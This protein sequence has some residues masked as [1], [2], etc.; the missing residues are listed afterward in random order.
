MNG[1]FSVLCFSCSMFS[2]PSGVSVELICFI[3]YKTTT[4]TTHFVQHNDGLILM[5]IW[6]NCK[7]SKYMYTESCCLYH[8]STFTIWGGWVDWTHYSS[9]FITDCKVSLNTDH[10]VDNAHWE[11]YSVNSL[12]HYSNYRTCNYDIL[13]V[14]IQSCTCIYGKPRESLWKHCLLKKSETWLDYTKVHYSWPHSDLVTSLCVYFMRGLY[15]NQNGFFLLQRLTKILVTCSSCCFLLRFSVFFLPEPFPWNRWDSCLKASFWFSM[16]PLSSTYSSLTSGLYPSFSLKSWI[17][18]PPPLYLSLF[19]LY[20]SSRSLSNR[21]CTVQPMSLQTCYKEINCHTCVL[22]Q[23]NYQQSHVLMNQYN[24]GF[25]WTLAM[26]DM[27]L[28]F[29][30]FKKVNCSHSNS[31]SF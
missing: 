6:I 28:L 3:S 10:K 29:S 2:V 27:K 4:A 8:T 16:R 22:K 12:Y 7:C 14:I 23:T 31:I 1:D 19:L 9:C 25:Q 18:P 15:I 5:P 13:L 21:I 11:S 20:F 17:I 24:S 30:H 26:S